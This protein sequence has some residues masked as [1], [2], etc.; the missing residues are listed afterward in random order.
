[1]VWARGWGWAA[2]GEEGMGESKGGRVGVGG[3]PTL[4]MMVPMAARKAVPL[5]P[6]VWRTQPCPPQQQVAGL[7]SKLKPTST[8]PMLAKKAPF[9][10]RYLTPVDRSIGMILA[11]NDGVRPMTA[12]PSPLLV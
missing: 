10:E 7:Q 6:T 1:M 2:R 9:F 12:G 11:G 5:P 4:V 3:G 8:S